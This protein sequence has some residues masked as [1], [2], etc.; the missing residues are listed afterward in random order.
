MLIRRF[1]DAEAVFHAGARALKNAGIKEDIIHH[2][3]RFSGWASLEKELLLLDKKDI[4]LLFFT[5]ADYPRRLLSSSDSPPLLFYK[6]TANLN[7]EK[8]IAIVGTRVPSEYGKQITEQLVQ[9]LAQ[10]GLVIISGLAYGIDSIAHKAS[11]KYN[12]PT[13]ALLGHGF[14]H[15]YPQENK[16]LARSMLQNGGLLTSYGLHEGPEMFHF[17]SRNKTVAALCDALIVVETA[18]RGGS[19]ITVNNAAAYGKKIFAVPGRLTD[20]RSSGCNW[21]ISE[22]KAEMLL[23]A[24][25]LQASMGWTWA[26]GQPGS[27]AELPFSNARDQDPMENWDQ[28]PI[29]K[30]LLKLLTENASISLDELAA[31]C[32]LP[33][34]AI[35]IH[36]LNLE[37]QGLVSSLPGRRFQLAYVP[38]DTNA[39]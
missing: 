37:L 29:E 32:S 28:D 12:I 11:L 14:G 22:K 8:I 10:P 23:S 21:L 2:I 1:G 25:Q 38:A 27:Q 3:T 31:C 36:L 4:R 20:S 34:S 19:L 39:A 17:P 7:A 9:K 5:S 18:R 13:V 26:A 24:D 16:E 35:S 33:C 15:I 6:G 30:N